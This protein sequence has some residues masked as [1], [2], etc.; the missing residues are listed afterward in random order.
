MDPCVVGADRRVRSEYTC[1]AKAEEKI[2]QR[3]RDAENRFREGPGRKANSREGREIMGHLPFGRVEL[4]SS[5]G[6]FFKREMK[7]IVSRSLACR[8]N[9][10]NPKTYVKVSAFR[11]PATAIR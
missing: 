1:G 4:H 8:R 9:C 6:A 2:A 10:D 11:A 5:W 7:S 3:R